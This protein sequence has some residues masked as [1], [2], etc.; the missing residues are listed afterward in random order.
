MRVLQTDRRLPL[1][2]LSP[3]DTSVYFDFERVLL[4]NGRSR[5]AVGRGTRCGPTLAAVQHPA[6]RLNTA[7]TADSPTIIQIFIRK[8][9][10]SFIFFP[11]W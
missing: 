10:I 11:A 9:L 8:Q 3:H 1:V 7:E 6:L 5:G 4:E 2:I